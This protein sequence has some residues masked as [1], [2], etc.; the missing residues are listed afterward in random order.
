M[1]RFRTG[2]GPLERGS[3]LIEVLIA[4]AILALLMVGVL[5]LF[6]V[7]LV[8]D[9][10]SAARTD[11]TMKAQQTAENLRYLHFLRSRSTPLPAGTGIPATITDGAQVNL[12][13]D[14]TEA[15]EPSW[16]YWGPAGANVMERAKGPY[17]VSYQYA[18]STTP[19]YWMVTV[20]V[21]SAQSGGASPTTSYLGSQAQ[22]KRVDYVFQ[23]HN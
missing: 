2:R 3:T 22:A 4:M 5:Q 18:A 11:M 20:T 6:S 14:G 21:Q 13:W 16:A 17:R 1:R 8:T 7:A 10:G 15:G 9:V 19:N 23:V 12:P